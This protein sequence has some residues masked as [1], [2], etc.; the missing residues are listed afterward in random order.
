MEPG[1][2]AGPAE[3]SA[4]VWQRPPLCAEIQ[5]VYDI[6]RTLTD[7][8][9]RSP[10]SGPTARARDSARPLEPDRH[11]LIAPS[12]SRL[13]RRPAVRGAEHGPGRR[14]HR[15]LGREVRVPVGAPVTAIRRE[16]DPTWSSAHRDPAVPS[17][18]SGHSTTSA[19]RPR[20]SR[21]SSRERRRAQGV[22]R[23]SCCLA[24]V[25]RDPL[26]ERQRGR[27][28]AR[29]E[30]RG[31]RDHALRRRTDLSFR[32]LVDD[33]DV[34]ARHALDALAHAVA[35]EALDRAELARPDDDEVDL[36]PKRDLHDRLRD[37]A[38]GLHELDVDPSSSSRPPVRRSS[39]PAAFRSPSS[40]P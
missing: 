36:V 18:V 27:T 6:S 7:R 20:C 25:R 1:R 30:R 2:L 13:A 3:P 38:D 9:S 28:R 16:I 21:A 35:E 17:Y 34:A 8:Q 4:R 37:V 10:T 33:E 5:E 14:V 24:P 23:G 32:A 15:L 40:R 39:V 11:R 26:P 29:Q 31:R 19:R 12:G 22:G